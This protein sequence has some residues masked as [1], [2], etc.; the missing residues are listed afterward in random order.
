M[1]ANVFAVYC[2]VVFALAI[3]ASAAGLI[4]VLS[5]ET[6]TWEE[7]QGWSQYF[8]QRMHYPFY[9][10]IAYVVVIFSLKHVMKDR[11]EFNLRTPLAAWSMLLATFSF[12]G[13]VRTVP[14]IVKM[15]LDKGFDHV[16]CSDTRSVSGFT[17]QRDGG[18]AFSSCPRSLSLSTRSLL[19][20]GNVG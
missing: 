5:F 18:H 12:M 17:A 20:S 8:M 3:G 19:Y 9:F 14:A 15:L 10:A 6:L 11:E 16:V 2:A 4:P 1:G 13:A 7:A